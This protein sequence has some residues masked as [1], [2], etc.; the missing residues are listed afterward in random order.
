MNL[1]SA[2]RHLQPVLWASLALCAVFL[3]CRSYFYADYVN[4]GTSSGWLATLSSVHGRF[5]GSLSDRGAVPT[6]AQRGV[7]FETYDDEPPDEWPGTSSIGRLLGTGSFH[8]GSSEMWSFLGI[9]C[10]S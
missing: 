8:T 2:R 10:G 6:A 5:V 7:F 1:A 9:E 3:M 4:Y